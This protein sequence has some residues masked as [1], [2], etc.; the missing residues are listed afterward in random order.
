M[1]WNANCTEIFSIKHRQTGD[2]IKTP[3]SASYRCPKSSRLLD[4]SFFMAGCL[5]FFCENP[6]G[7]IFRSAKNI[8][9]QALKDVVFH[10]WYWLFTCLQGSK[11]KT[12]VSLPLLGSIFSRPWFFGRQSK[13]KHSFLI[14]KLHGKN[15]KWKG[16]ATIKGFMY[17]TCWVFERIFHGS[18]FAQKYDLFQ[19]VSIPSSYFG[20]SPFFPETSETT[21]F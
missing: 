15:K 2:S 12:P 11:E 10:H 5:I 3:F 20:W 7:K 6:T 9:Y 17:Y 1:D 4:N 8:T 19:H 13:K 18:R 16:K 14:K 21:D